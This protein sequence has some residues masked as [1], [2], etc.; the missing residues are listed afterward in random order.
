MK[1]YLTDRRVFD[2]LRLPD[3]GPI[4]QNERLWIEFLRLVFYDE[5]PP[6]QIKI[7]F[8]RQVFCPPTRLSDFTRH[9]AERQSDG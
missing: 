2:G 9:E 1:D 3:D 8:A 4:N 6:P 7:S 5:V